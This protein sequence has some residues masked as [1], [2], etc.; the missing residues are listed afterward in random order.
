MT[1]K[2]TLFAGFAALSFATAAFGGDIMIDDPYARASGMSAKAGAAFFTIHNHG[3]EADRLVAATSEIS[4]VTELHTH[5]DMGD[6]IMKMV[7]VEEGFEVP[8]QG[9]HSLARGGDHVMFMGL[10]A[11]MTQGDVVSVTLTFEKA[12][13][14]VVEIPVD[15]ER[16][17]AMAHGEMKMDGEKM[18]NAKEGGAAM[19]GHNH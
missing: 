4:K 3:A 12:G 9:S 1:L 15:L 7:H 11:P 19:I 14:I 16:T 13:D 10:N 2:S 6:G 8:A 5:R 18:E 17:D